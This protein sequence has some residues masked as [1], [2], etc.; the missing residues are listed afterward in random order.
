MRV[1]IMEGLAELNPVSVLLNP[2]RRNM[3]TG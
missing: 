3:S 1:D 2:K